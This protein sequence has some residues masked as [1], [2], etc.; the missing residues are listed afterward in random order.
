[1]SNF[2]ALPSIIVG[3]LRLLR[4]GQIVGD[5]P[6]ELAVCEYDCRKLQCRFDEWAHC[7][8]RLSYLAGK[9]H[10]GGASPTKAE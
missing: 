10:S 9:E 8:K 7:E 1:M 2:L 3:K 6:P 4:K 5:V